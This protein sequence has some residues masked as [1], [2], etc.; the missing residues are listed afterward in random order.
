M[1][2]ITIAVAAAAALALA[3]CSEDAPVGAPAASTEGFDMGDA[4][5]GYVLGSALADASRPSVNH[6]YPSAPVVR[7][8][9]RASKPVASTPKVKVTTPTYRA[10]S[11]YSYRSTPSYRSSFSS[12]SSF[13]SSSFRAR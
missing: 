5:V 4:A 3:A 2:N 13:R 10:S 1:K 12:S 9:V 7:P 8:T 6:Y 11:S